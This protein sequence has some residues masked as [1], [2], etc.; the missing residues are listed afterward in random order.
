[1]SRPDESA[2]ARKISLLPPPPFLFRLAPRTAGAF[3]LIM[4]GLFRSNDAYMPDATWA[5][6]GHLPS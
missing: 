5:V 6:S 3:G 4:S 1:M 2:D